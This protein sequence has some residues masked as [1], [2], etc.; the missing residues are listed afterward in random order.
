M[1]P[2]ALDDLGCSLQWS[3]RWILHFWAPATPRQ[4]AGPLYRPSLL[5][6]ARAAQQHLQ[7]QMD[8]PPYSRGIRQRLAKAAKE[9]DWLNKYQIVVGE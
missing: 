3:Y 2:G 6:C 4:L 5:L 1:L 7:V 8:N 9:N